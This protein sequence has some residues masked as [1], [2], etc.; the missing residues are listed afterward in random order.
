MPDQARMTDKADRLV[1]GL[2]N[3]EER[4]SAAIVDAEALRSALDLVEEPDWP[5]YDPA[6][7]RQL[8]ETVRQLR[9]TVSNGAIRLDLDR[10]DRVLAAAGDS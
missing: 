3:L 10:I 6:V 1:S 8:R 5:D 4:L 2:E 7:Y 9:E